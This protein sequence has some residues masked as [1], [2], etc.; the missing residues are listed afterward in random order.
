MKSKEVQFW[1]FHLL[2]SRNLRIRLDLH[3]PNEIFFDSSLFFWSQL[4]WLCFSHHLN[5]FELV[6]EFTDEDLNWNTTKQSF[7]FLDIFFLINQFHDILE[8][9]LSQN[10]EDKVFRDAFFDLCQ[11]MVADLHNPSSWEWFNLDESISC[12]R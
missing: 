11:N 9:L 10:S 6:S 2:V 4:P 5:D 7:Q 3:S 8:L 12:M 1:S